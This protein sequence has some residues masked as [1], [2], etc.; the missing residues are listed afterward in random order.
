MLYSLI[1]NEYNSTQKMMDAKNVDSQSESF[2][3]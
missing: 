1:P 2:L 3:L